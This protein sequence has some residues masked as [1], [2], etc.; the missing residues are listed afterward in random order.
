ML[1]MNNLLALWILS[2]L[3]EL[4]ISIFNFTDYRHCSFY[5]L[6][7][8]SGKNR[9]ESSPF[10]LLPFRCLFYDLSNSI[11]LAWCRRHEQLKNDS[12]RS[13]ALHAQSLLSNHCPPPPTLQFAFIYSIFFM[14]SLCL[15]VANFE[16]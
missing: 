2:D 10:C 15:K 7:Y 3:P 11:F 6:P 5:F 12:I 9:E 14:K 1:T 16:L 8:S 4:S 13:H